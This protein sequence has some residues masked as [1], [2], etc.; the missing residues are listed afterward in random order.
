MSYRKQLEELRGTM[1]TSEFPC[2]KGDRCPLDVFHTLMLWILSAAQ[3]YGLGENGFSDIEGFIKE[4]K[5]NEFLNPEYCEE[6]LKLNQ[7]HHEAATGANP[8]KEE[9]TSL[10]MRTKSFY[11]AVMSMVIIED[12]EDDELSQ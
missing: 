10:V 3:S 8:A 11:R 6:L 9:I 4:L 2:P 12:D 7:E 1:Q 5:K